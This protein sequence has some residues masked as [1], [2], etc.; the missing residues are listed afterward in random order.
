MTKLQA[1][2]RA[3][4]L[5]KEG[6]AFIDISKALYSEGYAGPRSG[7]PIAISAVHSLLYRKSKTK[8][9]RKRSVEGARAAK[10]PPRTTWKMRSL[11]AWH[12]REWTLIS[13]SK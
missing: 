12:A 3:K 4:Q 11:E 1:I 7:K 5:R 13:N 6:M 9:R 8:K 2:K 10:E